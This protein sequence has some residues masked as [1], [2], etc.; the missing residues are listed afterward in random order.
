MLNKDSFLIRKMQLSD[1]SVVMQ[2]EEDVFTDIWSE[3]MFIDEITNHESWIYENE[4][5]EIVGYVCGWTIQDEFSITNVAVKKKFQRKGIANIFLQK[6]I[7]DKIDEGIKNFFLEVRRTN[8]PAI[9][10]YKKL[11]F[12]MFQVR[13]NYYSNPKED[14]IVMGLILK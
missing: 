3:E 2:I 4:L 5:S 10:F 8:F 14:A 6:I 11:N 1:L 13:K 7:N 12:R 9:N